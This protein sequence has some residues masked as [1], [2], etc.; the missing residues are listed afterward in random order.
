MCPSIGHGISDAVRNHLSLWVDEQVVDVLFDEYKKGG[1]ILNKEGSGGFRARV[2]DS[3]NW[4][5]KS[6]RNTSSG[7]ERLY[8]CKPVQKASLVVHSPQEDDRANGYVFQIDGKAVIGGKTKMKSTHVSTV[9]SK[10]DKSSARYSDVV[11]VK[12]SEEELRKM[13]T[14]ME[15]GDG[16]GHLEIERQA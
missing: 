9:L 14:E 2:K 1:G 5:R 15:F 13:R 3:K 7:F 8:Q 11:F 12:F 4:V 6:R 10:G 16:F